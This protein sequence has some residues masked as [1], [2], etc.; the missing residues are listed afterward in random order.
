M[1]RR[2]LLAFGIALTPLAAAL[3]A[4][5][6]EEQGGPWP[7]GMLPIKWDRDT[8]ARCGMVISDRRFAAEVRGGPKDTAFK[9]DDIGCA[10]TWCAEKT[11]QHPWLADAA[12]RYWVADYA[13]QGTKWLDARRA[14]Y[15][16]GSRSPMGYNLAAY[17]EAQPGRADFATISAKAA[18]NWPAGC[19]AGTVAASA[20][21]T[22]AA[23]RAE[24]P[25]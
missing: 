19:I 25:R 3:L 2:A 1:N 13:S 17:A 14:F 15:A 7:A 24:A 11:G 16:D 21:E 10:A 20:A 6:G 8:C 22:K 18:A 12:T 23:A 9:F 5:C 4:A